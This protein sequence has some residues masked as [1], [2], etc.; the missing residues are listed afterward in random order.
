MYFL[1]KIFF[2]NESR[3]K[4]DGIFCNEIYKR[5]GIVPR[6]EHFYKQAFTHRSVNKVDAKGNSINNERLEFL[7]DSVLNYITAIYLYDNL[8][9]KDEGSLTKMRSKLV[10]REHLNQIGKKLE[11]LK[12]L[13]TKTD[14]NRFNDNVEGNLIESLIGAIYLDYGIEMCRKVIVKYIINNFSSLESLEGKIASHKS[15]MIEFFQKKKWSFQF[16]TYESKNHKLKEQ[17]FESKL[18]V[19]G[20]EWSK[21]TATSKKKAEE[22]A[23]QRLYYKMR[24]KM[25]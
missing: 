12:L 9:S 21:A 4:K 17:V 19:N 11:V 1:K 22:K 16:E 14:I 7:G 13:D 3:S 5:I 8:P 15:Y 2:K 10:S 25:K 6:K 18:I 24:H 20:K 23:A